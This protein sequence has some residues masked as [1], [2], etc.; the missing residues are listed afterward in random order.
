MAGSDGTPDIQA[1]LKALQDGFGKKLPVR[2]DEITSIWAAVKANREDAELLHHLHLKLHSLTG[3]AATYHFDEVGSVARE[4]ELIA[5]AMA[6][7]GCIASEQQESDLDRAVARLCSV[8]SNPAEQ[9]SSEPSIA[10]E[11]PDGSI[12]AKKRVYIVDDQLDV[13]ESV[14]MQVSV[15]GY[16]VESFSNLKSFAAAFHENEPDAIIMDIMFEVSDTAGISMMAELNQDREITAKTIFIT[17]SQDMMSRLEAVR[18]GGV[19]YLPKPINMGQLI[20]TLDTITH[21]DSPEPFRVLIID[22]EVEQA[23]FVAL[24]LQQ[25]GMTTTIASKPLQA[26]QALNDFFPDLILMDIYM[27]EC[28]GLELSSV[29]RQMDAYVSVPI[30]FLSAEADLDKQLNAISLGADDFLTKPIVPWHLI[31]SVT[32]RIK[33]GRIIRAMAECDSMTGLL[34]HSS[35]KKRLDAE[36]SR[37]KRDATP[38]SFAMLDIDYFKHVN[39]T[40]GHPAGDRVLKCLSGLLRQ[41]LRITD[42]ISR[43]GG[44]EFVAILPNT[45]PAQAKGLMDSIR[46]DFSGIKQLGDDGDFT[47]TFSAGISYFPDRHDSTSLIDAADKLLYEAKEGG[48][49][50]VVTAEISS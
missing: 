21:K 6:A 41:R 18:A 27:P 23:E 43:Y 13:L 25:A 31:S 47:C 30:V 11:S 48:R 29:I 46:E 34:N 49:N 22:D 7:S 50:K 33:R 26:L 38:V 3:T 20:D 4:G 35:G 14:A 24:T 17:A 2:I 42:S 12:D 1:A 40:Y 16:E 15:F 32:S 5:K 45:T 39:D 8:S 9:I 37:S 10:T 36:L 19:A 44:E 28:T